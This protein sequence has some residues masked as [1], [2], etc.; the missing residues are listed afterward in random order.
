MP[1][2]DKRFIDNGFLMVYRILLLTNRENLHI[3]VSKTDNLF[4]KLLLRLSCLESNSC[5]TVK[6]AEKK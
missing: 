6:H 1:P 5:F 3:A 2:I 4:C